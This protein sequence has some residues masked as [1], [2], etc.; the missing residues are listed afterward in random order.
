[1]QSQSQIDKCELFFKM[2]FPG[3]DESC[4]KSF[5][6]RFNCNK[7]E[8]LKGHAPATSKREIA[9]NEKSGLFKCPTTDC[10][11][12]SE[13]KYNII[14]HLKSCD[15]VNKNKEGANENKICSFCSKVF[16]KK[17]IR[18]FHVKNFHTHENCSNEDESSEDSLYVTTM[19]EIPCTL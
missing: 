15:K 6:T 8:K 10:A 5:S 3:R 2:V 19:A 7:H 18:D 17:S 9:R 11:A 16:T 1:M 14:K 13:Y 4:K 12:A